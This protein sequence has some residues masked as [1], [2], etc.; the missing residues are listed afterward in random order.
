[1]S[2][3]RGDL[4]YVAAKGSFTTKPRPAVVVQA[5]AA[6]DW[7]E[8]VTVCL[9]TGEL[10]DAPMFRV[11]IMPSATNNLQKPSDV[12]ADKVITVRPRDLDETPIG[13]LSAAEMTLVDRALRFWL[14]L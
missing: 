13:R 3:R 7:R 4:V 6:A 11:R 5:D 2:L 10:S 12:M 9:L 14:A 1:M 8:S